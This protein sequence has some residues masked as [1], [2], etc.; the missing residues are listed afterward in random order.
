MRKCL[1]IGVILLGFQQCSALLFAQAVASTLP[2]VQPDSSVQEAQLVEQFQQ[3]QQTSSDQEEQPDA[4]PRRASDLDQVEYVP[5]LDGTG[6]IS[7]DHSVRSRF[8]LGVIYSGG[9]DT[10]PNTE[11]NAPKS[12]AFLLTPLVGIQANTVRTFYLIQYQPTFLRYT[13]DEYQG[14]AIQAASGDF[15]GSLEERWRWD[16]HVTLSHGQDSIRLL[17]PQQSV[18]V[19]DVPG[20]GPNTAA[21]RPNAGTTTAVD[22]RGNLTYLASQRDTVGLSLE[23]SFNTYTAVSGTNLVGTAIAE[24]AH[25]ATPHLQWFAYSS[26]SRYYGIIHCYAFGGGVGIDWKSEEHTYLHLGGGPQLNTSECRAQQNFSYDVAYSHRVTA[27]SQVYLTSAR[28]VGSTFVGPSLWQTGAAA[29]YQYD[30]G[31]KETIQ[32][33]FGYIGTSGVRRSD[34]YSGKYVDAI[35]SRSLG[36]NFSTSFSYRWYAGDLATTTRFNRTTALLSI[37]W[38]PTA[39]HLFQ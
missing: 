13:T 38:S 1:L 26:G 39:G 4:L 22:G 17:A 12:G 5:A 6:L 10:N 7:V 18:A 16:A 27:R 15:V 2:V 33:D 23:N 14:G 21:N 28:Q 24:Y 36:Y 30:F 37:G 9:Y 32:F 3:E 25:S 31:R 19:G 11:P 34:A 20:A 35:Y 29:G 8:L